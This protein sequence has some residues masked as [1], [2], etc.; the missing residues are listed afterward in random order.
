MLDRQFQLGV[1]AL[2][3]QTSFLK[4]PFGYALFFAE[5]AAPPT[6]NL[7]DIYL[8]AGP[9]VVIEILLIAMLAW[10][11]NLVIWLPELVLAQSDT[12]LLN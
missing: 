4:P 6:V 9:L 1:I 3:L 12:P 2:T 7:A 5:M 11:P 10:W 8:G